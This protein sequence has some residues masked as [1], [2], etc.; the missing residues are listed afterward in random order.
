[1]ETLKILEQ[2]SDRLERLSNLD[3]LHSG[4]EVQGEALTCTRAIRNA[5]S[6]VAEV[7]SL[8]CRRLG[9]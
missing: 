7:A 2:L 5:V 4:D 6:G 1:M 9:L 8:E 3:T